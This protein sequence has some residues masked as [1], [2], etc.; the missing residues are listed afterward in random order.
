[1]RSTYIAAVFIAF[2]AAPALAQ[3]AP[4]GTTMRVVG[5]V[6]KLDG[7]NLTV[8]MRDGS[9]VT[10]MLADTAAVFGATRS[11]RTQS[12]AG[13]VALEEEN[14]SVRPLQKPQGL[15]HDWRIRHGDLD[16]GHYPAVRLRYWLWGA[17]SELHPNGRTLFNEALWRAP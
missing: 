17:E 12:W 13:P 4:S 5:T 2:L 14:E 8:N 6:D 1:M 10:V 15:C 7:N 3:T 16:A 11:A 9:A